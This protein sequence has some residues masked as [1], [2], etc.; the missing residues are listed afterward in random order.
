MSRGLNQLVAGIGAGDRRTLAQAITLIESNRDED[1]EASQQLLEAISADTGSAI[2][3]GITGV[4]GVG[5]STFI[6]AFGSMLTNQGMKVAVLAV[7]PS[8]TVSG[9]SI[10]GDKT[11]MDALSRDPNAFVRPS[12]GGGATGGVARYTREAILV[13][14]AAGFDVVLVE[15]MGVGQSEIAVAQMVDT[16]VLLMLTGAGDELQGIKRGIMELAD[17][18]VIHKADGANEQPAQVAAREYAGALALL[19]N[20]FAGW[21]PAVLTCSSQTGE[22]IDEVFAKIEAHRAALGDAGLAEFRRE[23]A[24]HWFDETLRE[25]LV[26]DFLKRD[27]VAKSLPEI[28]TAV[29]SGQLQPTAAVLELLAH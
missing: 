16:F 29:R 10:L 27:H 26:R 13:C 28:R 6:D 3:I 12:P 1:L 19:P 21:D 25:M 23:Q 7:D 15:T 11:R 9:G 14:E 17:L 22:G 2:R 24:L 5:K 8:S 18:V 20:R 4:P